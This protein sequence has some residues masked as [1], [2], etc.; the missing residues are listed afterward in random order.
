MSSAVVKAGPGQVALL[1]FAPHQIALIR[2][3]IAR[4]CDE[5]EFN[6][7]MEVARMRGLNPFSNQ[8]SPLV[9]SKHDADKRNMVIL[10]RID[11]ARAIA[12]RLPDYRPMAEPALIEC[13]QAAKD[14]LCNPLGIVRAQVTLWKHIHGDWHPVVG[15]AYWDEYAP[16]KEDCPDGYEWIETGEVWAD[17]GKPKKKKAAKSTGKVRML[18]LSGNWGRMPRVMIAKC[19]EMQALR[20][21]WPETYSGLYADEEIDRSRVIDVASEVVADYEEAERAKRIAA[22]GQTLLMV[23]DPEIGV[24]AV[25]RG[26]VADRLYAAYRE[27]ASEQEI[28]DLRRRNEQALKTFWSWAPGDAL[29]LKKFAEQRVAVLREHGI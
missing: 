12:A 21:G 29:E 16:I 20:R 17:S 13:D 6:L 4:D 9:F 19:A 27:A 7:F 1:D 11:G 24:E 23:F 10:T 26:Q 3:T 2:K 18:D 22:G 25:P 28:A 5:Q 8:I 14:P 15:E